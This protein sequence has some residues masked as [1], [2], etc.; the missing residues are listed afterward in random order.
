M[1]K[2]IFDWLLGDEL[3]TLKARINAFEQ[4]Q[5]SHATMVQYD[6]VRYAV[7]KL[8]L[9]NGGSLKHGQGVDECVTWARH[10]L[11]VAGSS[12]EDI[13]KLRELVEERI[14]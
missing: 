7:D 12:T 6:A 5:K 10:Y 13:T 1:R 14:G 11:S 9:E 8:R 2:L 3:N 4:C